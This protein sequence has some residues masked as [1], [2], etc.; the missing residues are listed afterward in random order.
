[1]TD[2][3]VG[4]GGLSVRGDSTACPLAFG[5]DTYYNCAFQCNYCSFLGLTQWCGPD[6][7][8]IDVDETLRRLS[9]HHGGHSPLSMCIAQRKTLRLGNK[10]DP[11]PPCEKELGVTRA[12]MSWLREQRWQYKLETKNLSLAWDY[13][14][15]I[16]GAKAIITSTVLI[17][18]DRDWKVFEP[19][20]PDSA[21][22]RLEILQKFAELGFQVGVISEPFMAPYHT[23]E[24]WDAYTNVLLSY[25]IRRVNC[26][27]I[28]ITEYNAK[29][30]AG[31][32]LD[33]TA[34]YDA[35]SMWPQTLP[36]L[37]ALAENKGMIVGSP[38]FVNARGHCERANTC[39][40][41]DV[42]TPCTFNTVTWKRQALLSGE[43][44]LRDGFEASW[45]GVGDYQSGLDL[46]LGEAE[47]MYSLADCVELKPIPSGWKR[48]ED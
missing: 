2:V 18:L 16:E 45:D 7:R 1:M 37:I 34:M 46:F 30:M 32:G 29:R 17:G 12:V 44:T 48:R 13:L 25:G 24:D 3:R 9:S 43:I 15:V 6:Y 36:R 39:C 20:V 23:L 22:C 21:S 28:T 11:M 38:D 27:P 14:D 10:Y 4:Y 40:A 31:A 26:Y 47:G 41:V 33:I 19:N 5:L 35:L 8:V 42:E